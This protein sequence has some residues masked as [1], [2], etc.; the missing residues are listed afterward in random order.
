MITVWLLKMQEEAETGV[1][2]SQRHGAMCPAC[3]QRAKI[4]STKPWEGPVR[5]RYHR[6]SN[7]QCVLCRAGKTIKSVEED[8]TGVETA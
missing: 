6:C 1:V 5:I 2:F 3:N 7:P 4:Y 8:V